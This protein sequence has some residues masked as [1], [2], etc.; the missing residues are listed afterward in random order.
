MFPGLAELSVGVNYRSAIV[1]NAAAITHMKK[2]GYV[3]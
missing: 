3:G 2:S 1:F